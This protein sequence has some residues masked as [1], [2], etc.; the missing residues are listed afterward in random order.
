MQRRLRFPGQP[1]FGRTL[2]QL[3]QND[4]GVRGAD[5]F[6]HLNDPPKAQ[7][8]AR[9]TWQPVSQ[10]PG[11][12]AQVQVRVALQDPAQGRLGQVAQIGQRLLGLFA[13]GKLGTAEVDEQPLEVFRGR[14]GDRLH[15]LP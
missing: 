13:H 12:L 15:P 2:G 1:A 6:Q 9:P 11:P 4:S 5:C 7:A 8:L 3:L 10:R 14:R